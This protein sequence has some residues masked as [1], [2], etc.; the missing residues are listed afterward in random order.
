MDPGISPVLHITPG[1]ELE[2]TSERE[3]EL[4]GEVG[5]VHGGGVCR[6]S[7]AAEKALS[8]VLAR[9]GLGSCLQAREGWV[10][11]RARRWVWGSGE[12]GA[13]GGGRYRL[14]LLWPILNVNAAPDYPQHAPLE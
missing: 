12:Q 3:R 8:G 7:R 2:S 5:R 4:E 13:H 10:A 6:A 14:G 9:E 1:V 11:G